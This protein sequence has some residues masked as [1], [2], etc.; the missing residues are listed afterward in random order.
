[1]F[2]TGAYLADGLKLAGWT[3]IDLWLAALAIGGNLDCPEIQGA[4]TGALPPGPV[5]YDTLVLAFNERFADCG[6]DRPM[7]SWHELPAF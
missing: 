5:D 1:M 4:V 6:L 2:D 7:L 3:V